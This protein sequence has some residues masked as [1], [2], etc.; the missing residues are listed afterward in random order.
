L[1]PVD[2]RAQ[3]NCYTDSQMEVE[4]ECGEQ[5]RGISRWVDV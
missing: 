1:R 5:W 3:Y 4:A 2:F